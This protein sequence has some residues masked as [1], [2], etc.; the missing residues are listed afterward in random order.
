[1]HEDEILIGARVKALRLKLGYTTKQMAAKTHISEKRLI[2]LENGDVNTVKLS[3]LY[4][5]A[6][7]GNTSIQELLDRKVIKNA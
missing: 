2:L 5:I 3:E 6:E 7:V 1:M 4:R